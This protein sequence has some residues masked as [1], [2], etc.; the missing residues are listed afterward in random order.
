[1]IL[2]CN[3]LT[4]GY[5]KEVI[6]TGISFEIPENSYTVVL[7]DNGAGKTT[8]VRTIAGLLPIMAGSIEMNPVVT[9]GYL[10][11]QSEIQTNFPT[12]VEEI[13]L[14][15][16]QGKTGLFY[17]GEQ[18]KTAENALQKVG[19]ADFHRKGFG[20]LSGGQKQ[21]VLLARALCAMN[22]F[23]VLDEP[24]TGL[25]VK[26]QEML[27]GLVEQLHK[28]GISILMISHDRDI[29]EKNATHVLSVEEKGVTYQS[30]E[31]Y[32]ARGYGK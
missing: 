32:I 10:P 11:Q 25:D 30:K 8:L 22:G 13:V 19:L 31:D 1:M 7:G 18:K 27:Y 28:E 23:L 17:S 5:G 21:R 2:R 9:M 16:M 26:N 29:L 15:G 20:E 4:I 6:H 24:I 12:T 14:S 3:G